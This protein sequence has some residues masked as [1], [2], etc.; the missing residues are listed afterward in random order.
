[1]DNVLLGLRVR[2]PMGIDICLLGLLCFVTYSYVSA[3]FRL[4]S[5][6]VCA[7]REVPANEKNLQ[8]K[9]TLEILFCGN[10]GNFLE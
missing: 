10:D 9:R 1:M 2:I 7:I 5:A 4:K 8:S 6:I 3:L